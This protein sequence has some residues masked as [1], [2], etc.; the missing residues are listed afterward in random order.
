MIIDTHSHIYSEQFDLDRDEMIQRALNNDVGIIMMPNVDL[1]TIQPMLEIESR[2]PKQC[3]PMMGMHPTNVDSNYKS[4]LNEMY[5][6]L[7]K[8][9][10]YAVGEIG[11][12]LYWDKTFVKEQIEAFKIQIAWAKEFCLPIVI[13]ARDAFDE[14]FDALDQVGTNGLSGVFHSFTGNY[15]Q[16]QK[17]LSYPNFLL[18]INGVITFKNSGLDKVVKKLSIDNLVLETDA[19]YLTPTPYRGKR[20]E[21]NYIHL[22]ADKIAELFEIS[23]DEVNKVTTNNAIELFKISH[24]WRN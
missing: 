17:A 19:P 10:Y 4:K 15:E 3:L 20:N 21:P 11:I 14:V 23:V 9:H 22:V 2:F 24:K 5:D 12:D 16:A 8:H 13:H 18:S 1:D 6:H 7:K